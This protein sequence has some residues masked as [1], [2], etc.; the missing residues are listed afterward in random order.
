MRGIG[1]RL[2]KIEARLGPPEKPVADR[3]PWDWFGDACPCGLPLGDCVIHPRARQAQRPP[4]G[5]WRV[6]GYIAGRGAGKTR[7]GACWIQNRVETGVM[8]LGCLIAPTAA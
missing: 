5:S 6:W 2:A 7:A 4:D 3:S 1:N 8:R